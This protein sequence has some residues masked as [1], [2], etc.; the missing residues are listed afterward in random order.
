[1]SIK[2]RGKGFEAY[3]AVNGQRIR[4]I[5]PTLEEAQR[6]E[7]NAK[8]AILEGRTIDTPRNASAWTLQVAFERC[9]KAHWEGSKGEK[10][11]S[12]NTAAALAFFGRNVYVSEVT[13]QRVADWIERLKVEK[14]SNGTINRKLSALSKALKYAYQNDAL[15][16]LP[17]MPRLKEGQG[18]L[19]FLTKD[20]EERLLNL[21]TQWSD[22]ELWDCVATLLDT[23]LRCGEL[24]KLEGQDVRNGQI[25][26][27]DTKNGKEH[28]VPLTQRASRIVSE[29]MAQYGR[30][31]LYPHSYDSLEKRFRRV[32]EHLQM[33]DVTFHVL[34]HT[35][36][37]RLVQRGV[38]IQTVSKLLNHS[39]IQITMRYAH[40]APS[41][42]V[43]AVRVL[44]DV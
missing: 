3:I 25:T 43:D 21:I 15:D 1:V 31:K 2:P 27:W 5:L 14:N 4:R 35:F 11:V 40:L 20:E 13:T 16:K 32:T 23:G 6:F 8:L 29:R 9:H 33:D 17:Y 37:S 44:E 36:A 18:R 24:L 39:T 42:L 34:R 19:R 38:P 7:A 30:G 10:T 41:N 26:V 12:F 22:Q 28:T